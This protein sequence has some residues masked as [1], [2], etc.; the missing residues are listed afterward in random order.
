LGLK[1]KD[2]APARPGSAIT[3]AAAPAVANTP[4]RVMVIGFP[5]LMSRSFATDIAIA[6]RRF[7]KA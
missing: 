4:R 1:S 2:C 6:R 5:P 3:A 7:A